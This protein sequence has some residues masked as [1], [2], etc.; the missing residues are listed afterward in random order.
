MR[1]AIIG[2]GVSGLVAAYL[3]HE[4]HDITVFEARDRIGGH[5]NT[6]D[7]EEEDGSVRAVDTGFIVYN[8]HNYPLFTKLLRQL[9]VATQPSDM[10]FGVRSDRNGI[11]YSSATMQTRLVD[12]ADISQ[13]VFGS[14]GNPLPDLDPTSVDV[15]VVELDTVEDNASVSLGRIAFVPE[16]E[17]LPLLW[18]CLPLWIG[19]RRHVVQHVISQNQKIANSNHPCERNSEI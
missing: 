8:E 18:C 12:L 15:I 14:P 19:T 5:V 7:V 17:L 4:R 6:V 16:P 3:L 10:S 13:P 2:S 1:I 9:E 11:E